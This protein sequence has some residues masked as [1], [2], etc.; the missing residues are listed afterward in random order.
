MYMSWLM[1]T[2]HLY[3]QIC[4][5]MQM[6]WVMSHTSECMCDMICDMTELD[7]R[8]DSFVCVTWLIHRC[9]A[10]H[11]YVQRDSFV[12]ATWHGTRPI[13]MRDMTHLYL[14]WLICMWSPNAVTQLVHQ[15]QNSFIFALW[16]IHTCGVNHRYVRCDAF[17]CATRLIHMCNMIV[18]MCDMTH[19]RHV[20]R[21]NET[22]CTCDESCSHVRHDS[23]HLRNDS[24]S[25]RT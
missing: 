23:C 20:T 14:T 1:D 9:D 8:R 19:F 17:G 6:R 25:C 21:V 12:C 5:P 3:D 13:H 15:W 11:T 18:L 2:E 7:L 22:C 16:L 10:I 4:K 24:F